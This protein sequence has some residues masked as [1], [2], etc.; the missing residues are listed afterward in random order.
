[1]DGYA[2][3]RFSAYFVA[4]VFFLAFF[5]LFRGGALHA[6]EA[7]LASTSPASSCIRYSDD[8]GRGIIPYN[9][10]LIDGRLLAAGTPFHP[11]MPSNTASHVANIFA[12]IA[13]DGITSVVILNVPLKDRQIQ[14]EEELAAA[15]GLRTYRI[16][17]N[18]DKV[19][20]ASETALILRLIE[21]HAYIHCQWGADRTG[22]VIAKYLRSRCEYSGRTAWEAIIKG[23][24]H[25]GR[26][27]GF[28]IDPKY[29]RL[30]EYFWPEVRTEDRDVCRM[31]S[32]P[33]N[34]PTQ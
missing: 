26:Q 7:G 29:A 5:F 31:Y 24:S 15:A 18:A 17:M 34:P 22:V 11:Q 2:Q 19:P 27:G 33:F 30:L 4:A 3:N 6:G 25:A 14:Q 13:S 9:A 8:S 1:M 23:G 10:R 21:N 16:P 28:K 20:S 12:R 32:I